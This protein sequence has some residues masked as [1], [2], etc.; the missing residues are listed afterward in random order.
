[1]AGSWRVAMVEAGEM[2]FTIRKC[3]CIQDAS[4]TQVY[5]LPMIPPSAPP[6]IGTHLRTADIAVA[7]LVLGIVVL[8]MWNIL[9]NM[10]AAG[11]SPGF[12]FLWQEAGF[13]VSEA[14]IP[15]QPSDS[16]ARVILAGLL[17]TVFLASICLVVSTLVGVAFGL[18]SVGPSP[19]GRAVAMAYVELFRNLPK[20][21]VLLVL[22][23]V[24]VN[25][26]PHV[27]QAI[28]LGPIYLSNRSVAF[29]V[30]IFGEGAWIPFA[31]AL[32]V[33]AI[34]A[35]RKYL[36]RRSAEAHDNSRTERV[37]IAAA[38]VLLPVL[39]ML[40]FGVRIDVSVPEL[41]GFD[42]SGGGRLSTQFLVIVMT[43]G[44]YHGAQIAEVV[45][46]G[47]K[48]IPV[49]QTEAAA[50]LGLK[51]RQTVRFVILP[52][53]L[54]LILPPM[55]NQYVNLIKNTSIAIAVGYSDLMSVS[56]TI[57][58]QTFK[59]LEMMLITMGLYLGLCACLTTLT[60]RYHARL[61]KREGR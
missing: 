61:T 15:Y 22:Y 9:A 43:L 44:L 10:S 38:L 13:D 31:A 23:V 8:A 14:L 35:C 28:S 12:D 50:A 54:R 53:V 49:G 11:I 36:R 16:Y 26:L 1:M 21:L 42:F 46:G 57:I 58:N 40:I 32:A 6:P 30:I 33:V 47:L 20:L 17:N 24:A 59:P 37:I 51:R 41:K 56:G 48:A 45:R 7:G 34:A 55:N 19:V 52:Q 60:N 4:V 18:I 25:G 29:P 27:R 3:T 2:R 39:T 5:M